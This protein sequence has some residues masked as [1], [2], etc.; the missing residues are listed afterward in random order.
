MIYP[1]RDFEKASC[2]DAAIDKVELIN[3]FD[4][5]EEKQYNIHSMVLL[6]DGA[7]I[8][9]VY[10]DSFGPNTREEIYSISKSFTSIAIGI[11]QDLGY[12]TL[13]Q[14]AYSFFRDQVKHPIDGA[15]QITI[16][17]LLTMT[18]GHSKDFLFEANPKQSLI[19][20]FFSLPL[21]HEVGTYF[22]YNNFATYMLS[23][24]VSRVTGK[25]LNDFLDE[26]LY[27]KIGIVKPIW[28]EYQ[29]ISIGAYGLALGALDLARFGH[30]LLSEGTWK[31]EQIVS[32]AYIREATANHISTSHVENPKDRYGYGYQFWMNDFQDYRAAGLYKQY[33]VINKEFNCVFVVQAYEDRELLDLFTTHILGGFMKGWQYTYHSLRDGLYRFHIQSKP[34]IETEKQNRTEGQ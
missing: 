34:R 27:H 25:T 32:R 15:Q 29:G 13:D 17:H 28:K 1:T 22:V 9:D 7:K 11:C 10:A 12:L 3:L 26:V 20:T 19:E 4:V 6:R 5:I 31:G 21:E 30:L 16:R 14:S 8:F 18:V 2:R 24:I 23:A 33:I